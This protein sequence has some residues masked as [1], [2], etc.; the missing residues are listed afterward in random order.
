MQFWLKKEDVDLIIRIIKVFPE[1][2]SAKIFW[3]RAMWNYEHGSDIDI[4][5]F[6]VDYDKAYE[7]KNLLKGSRLW[8]YKFDITSYE[9]ITNENLKR[10]ID[11]F[12][13]I[14]F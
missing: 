14:L 3:S 7:V 4:A 5:V 11:E 2:K 12:W 1:I 6:W 13:V 9:G 8:Y 10:H